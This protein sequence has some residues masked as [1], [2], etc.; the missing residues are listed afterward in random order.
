MLLFR[1]YILLYKTHSY[2]HMHSPPLW[3]VAK[4]I[5]LFH[6]GKKMP[7]SLE[8]ADYRAGLMWLISPLEQNQWITCIVPTMEVFHFPGACEAERLQAW[9]ALCVAS[10]CSFKARKYLW[11]KFLCSVEQRNVTG[12]E[13]MEFSIDV[14]LMIR[15]K[16]ITIQGTG[17]A[18]KFQHHEN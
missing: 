5:S 13:P 3:T 14:F 1:L 15:I 2:V 12:R 18:C 16:Q 7:S 8:F 11:I 9:N 6:L 10:T 4:P 17:E